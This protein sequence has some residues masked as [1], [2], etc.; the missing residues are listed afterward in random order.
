MPDYERQMLV[1]LRL[2]QASAEKRQLP[3]RDKLLLLAGVAACRAGWPDIADRCRALVIAHN[4]R[5]LVAGSATFADALRDPE[6]AP[7]FRQLERFCPFE[8]AELLARG[9]G[10]ASPSQPSDNAGESA[11]QMLDAIAAGGGESVDLT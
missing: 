8:R 2:A 1:Y 3:G 6:L 10:A 7:F 4:P 9:A 11:A 5:H